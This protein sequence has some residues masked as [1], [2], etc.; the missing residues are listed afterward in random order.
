MAL[1]SYTNLVS[2]VADWLQDSNV[3]SVIPDWITLVETDINN[4]LRIQA[5]EVT[6]D[7][8]TVSARLTAFPTDF[9]EWRE[10]RHNSSPYE[11]LDLVG[12]DWANEH[13]NWLDTGRPKKFL[14]EAGQL[15]MVPTPD[16]PY[17]LIV[18]YY[19]ALT[20]LSGSNPTNWIL[21]NR[22]NIYLFGTLAQS[23][24]YLGSD[25]RIQTWEAMY[26]KAL[27][28]LIRSDQRAR[29]S[30]STPAMRVQLAP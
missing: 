6:D 13:Y 19:A 22:P 27:A 7:A 30:G 11:K 18:T 10:L 26:E 25:E 16:T 2:A 28:D 9:L 8:F 23:K 21:T 24:G 17:T 4:R 12:A 15:R 3:T 29:W 1:D 14:N 5:M 20:P